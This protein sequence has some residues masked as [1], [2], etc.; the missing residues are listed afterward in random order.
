MY[1][2]DILG[3]PIR[4]ICLH[5]LNRMDDL[6]PR[7]RPPKNCMLPTNHGIAVVVMKN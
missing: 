5:I 7:D 3:R 6:Q 4:L 2:T 1:N